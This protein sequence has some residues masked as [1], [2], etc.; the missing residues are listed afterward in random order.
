M[1]PN[2]LLYAEID[3]TFA[4]RVISTW[5]AFTSC[6]SMSVSD[7]I[8]LRQ[9]VPDR[10]VWLS[11]SL[12]CSTLKL[13]PE[14]EP[15][16]SFDCKILCEI[17]QLLPTADTLILTITKDQPHVLRVGEVGQL[18]IIPALSLDYQTATGNLCEFND[19]EDLRDFIGSIEDCECVHFSMLL[20]ASSV[21]FN[22]GSACKSWAVTPTEP[23]AALHIHGAYAIPLINLRDAIQSID[24]CQLLVTPI[25]TAAIT[26]TLGQNQFCIHLASTNTSTSTLG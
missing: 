2:A 19:T 18:E 6:C 8:E 25:G 21:W 14:L 10:N 23:T 22:I 11:A 24:Q 9:F 12:E 4:Q 17:L 13:N 26:H 5:S 3:R 15:V 1:Y 20:S 7:G 16:I